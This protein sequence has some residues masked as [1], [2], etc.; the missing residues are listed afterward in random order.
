MSITRTIAEHVASC[1]FDQLDAAAIEATRRHILYTT[2]TSFAGAGAPGIA[3]VMQAASELAPG[4]ASSVFGHGTRLAAN[5]AALVNAAMAHSRELDINDDRIAYKSSVAVVPAAWAVAEALTGVSG[6]DFL[7]AVCVGIDLGIR[8]GLAMEPKPAHARFI[9]LGPIAAAA[10]CAKLMKLDAQGVHDALGIAYC[11]STISGN[12]LASPSLTKRLGAGFAAQAGVV[13]ATLARAGFPASTEIFSGTE[14][15]FQTFYGQEGDHIALLDGLGTRFEIVSVG[16]KPFP[17]CR[18]THAAVSAALALRAEHGVDARAI[19]AVRVH[20]GER[21]MRMV[22]GTSEE[23]RRHRIRPQGVVDAQFSIPF[24][25]AAALVRGH[26][27]LEEFTESGLQSPD[28]LAL[29]ARLEPVEEPAF[30]DWPMDVRPQ[31]VELTLADGRVVASRVDYP[32]GSCENP[33]TREEVE[34]AFR[35]MARFSRKLSSGAIEDI[36]AQTRKLDALDN[37]TGI[38][39]LLNAR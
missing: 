30:D 36:V 39:P 38:I 20:V 4:M 23:E 15:F 14:G 1:S 32:K 7:T 33:F 19:R 6:R 31:R 21:D 22:W 18:Y 37:L 5:G 2:G 8:L 24:T 10:A 3:Q 16:P 29:A 28:I 35:A 27:T 17:S 11:R 12:S 9:A 34:D 26:L 13:A 25:V